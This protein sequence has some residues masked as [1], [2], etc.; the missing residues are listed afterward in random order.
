M[1]TRERDWSHVTSLSTLLE[2]LIEDVPGIK[3]ERSSDG[4]IILDFKGKYMG[5]EAGFLDYMDEKEILYWMHV[6]A[7]GDSTKFLAEYKD[8]KEYER[9]VC[10]E[11]EV[12]I[13]V[14]FLEIESA[15]FSNQ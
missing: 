2:R 3:I 11:H 9:E 7:D 1:K 10:L 6:N 15:K 13:P 14:R 4:T 12:E 8:W 5:I